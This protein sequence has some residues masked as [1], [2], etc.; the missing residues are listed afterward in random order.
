M[1][2]NKANKEAWEEAFAKH[3]QGYKEDDARTALLKIGLEGKTVAQ[4]CCNNG[5][6]LLTLL[7][8]G[9]DAG[10][11][12]DI[13]ENFTNEGRRIKRCGRLIALFA[14]ACAPL[15][16]PSFRL[17]RPDGRKKGGGTP[18]RGRG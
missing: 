7:N 8:M 5:R 2:Y 1:D 4:F 6:E 3:Q 11:G 14:A 12:F 10:T 16:G 17:G 13:T 15:P 9:A 18:L